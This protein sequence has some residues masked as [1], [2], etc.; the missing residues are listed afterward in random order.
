MVDAVK[1]VNQEGARGSGTCCFHRRWSGKASLESYLLL[2][3]GLRPKYQKE[4][5]CDDLGEE[6]SQQKEEQ[7]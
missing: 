3:F 5:A 2:L 7:A 6:N 4:T 1:K